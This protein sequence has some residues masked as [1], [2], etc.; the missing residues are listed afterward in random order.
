MDHFFSSLLFIFFLLA[1]HL[2]Y[3]LKR[4][5]MEKVFAPLSS[6]I[7]I[8]WVLICGIVFRYS[9]WS[10]PLLLAVL[11]IALFAFYQDWTTKYFSSR[12]LM[13]FFII[14]FCIPY[15]PV[16]CYSRWIACIYVGILGIFVHFKWLG[17]A[18]LIYMFVIGGLIGFRRLI[19][20]LGVSSIMGLI[21]AIC[22]RKTYVP[23]ISVLVINSVWILTLT[24]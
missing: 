9:F 13:F 3:G 17:L 15:C 1:I 20:L 2:Y 16:E 23:F 8:V 24:F 14:P 7:L 18:D 4:S 5:R 19:L 10:D 12:W 21:D 6:A 22:A 11:S